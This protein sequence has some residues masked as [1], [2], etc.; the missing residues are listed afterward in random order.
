M[1][2]ALLHLKALFSSFSSL[3]SRVF[4]ELEEEISEVSHQ[5]A[6]SSS[7]VRP[8]PGNAQILVFKIRS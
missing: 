3:G 7:E 6:P 1:Y 2:K 4:K 5:R 8:G